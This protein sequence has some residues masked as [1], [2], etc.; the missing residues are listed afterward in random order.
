MKKPQLVDIVKSVD[1]LREIYKAG[2]LSY[3]NNKESGFTIYADESLSNPIVNAAILGEEHSIESE[4]TEGSSHLPGEGSYL[5][6]L[7][8]RLAHVHFHPP[9]SSL[10]PSKND[11]IDCLSAKNANYAIR[12]SS[13]D[14]Q[15]EIIDKNDEFKII[16]YEVD[17]PNPVSIIGIANNN[18]ENIELL[19]YQAI[20]DEPIEFFD[21]LNIEDEASI[22]HFFSF[23]HYFSAPKIVNFL[24]RLKSFQAT[25]LKVNNGKISRDGLKRLEKFKLIK[26]RF[27]PVH[28]RFR[29]G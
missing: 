2:R 17:Y 5:P 7:H 28:Y 29:E 26:T 12:D 13:S 16:G 22:L 8:Y 19:V 6:E 1:F 24:N 14:F 21:L 23:K 9:A 4:M 11:I 25:Y 20:T 27:F 18:P 10:H 3:E 15:K